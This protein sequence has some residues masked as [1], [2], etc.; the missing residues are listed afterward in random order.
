MG[1]RTVG[2]DL[3]TRGDHVARVLD[4]GCPHGRPIRFRLMSD[5]LNHLVARLRDG[6]APDSPSRR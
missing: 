3:A 4:D 1:Q 6:A 2:I 5:G